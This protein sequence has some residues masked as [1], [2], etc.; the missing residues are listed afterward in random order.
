MPFR[1]SGTRLKASRVVWHAHPDLP[2]P[3]IPSTRHDQPV[4]CRMVLAASRRASQGSA[5]APSPAP[6]LKTPGQR[7]WGMQRC[8]G[9]RL[10]TSARRAGEKGLMEG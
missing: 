4:P 8:H 1:P 2:M 7:K 9:R 5:M 6:R 3:S 10:A